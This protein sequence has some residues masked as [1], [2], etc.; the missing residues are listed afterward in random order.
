MKGRVRRGK[1]GEEGIMSM[2]EA[3]V[4]WLMDVGP[5]EGREPPDAAERG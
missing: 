5:S 3:I 2:N 1:V 4:T